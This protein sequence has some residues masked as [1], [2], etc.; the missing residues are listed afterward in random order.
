[1][2]KYTINAQRTHWY[3]V[4]V[5]ADSEREALD[6]VRDWIAEDFEESETRA[7]WDFDVEES[8]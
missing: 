7:Q 3:T 5:E 8:E 1:M 2:T 4:E 6:E